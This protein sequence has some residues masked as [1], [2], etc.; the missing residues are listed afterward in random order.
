M[1]STQR[2]IH[3]KE[4]CC[5]WGTER[6]LHHLAFAGVS[7]RKRTDKANRLPRYLWH[8]AVV[9][10]LLDNALDHTEEI[11]VLP[12]ITINV[13]D[14]GI[15]VQDN[16]D[17]IPPDIVAGMLDLEKRVSSREAYRCPTRGAQGNAGKCLL[18]VPYVCNEDE[19]GRVTIKAQGIRHDITVELDQIEQTRRSSTCRRPKKYIM[20]LSSKCI[21]AIYQANWTDGKRPDLYFSLGIT[22]H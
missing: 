20:A 11:G 5:Q 17:G 14:E 1:D 21:S 19:P 16:G 8:L 2:I 3:G 15:S 6:S 18:G 22:R 12:E 9:K 4:C 13:D 7:E 10:E